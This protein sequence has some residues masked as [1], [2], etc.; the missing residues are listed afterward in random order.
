MGHHQIA[1]IP[2][3]SKKVL[4]ENLQELGSDGLVVRKDLSNTILHVEYGL[5][6][7]MRMPINS[8][9]EH[10]KILSKSHLDVRG[11]STKGRIKLTEVTVHSSKEGS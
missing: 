5:S 7:G 10:L 11:N 1:L 3:A 2:S 6:E 9:L 8:L 4:T